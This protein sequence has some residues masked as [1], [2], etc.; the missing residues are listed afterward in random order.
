MKLKSIYESIIAEGMQADPRG[1]LT[2]Q[3]KLKDADAKFKSL[4]KEKREYFDRES[5]INPYDDTRIL[6]G[7]PDAEIKTAI[8]GIDIDTS[9]LLL[10]DRLNAKK[11]GKIDLAVSHHPQGAAYAHFYKVMDMQADIFHNIGVPINICEQL[12][13][14]RKKEVSR[15]IHAANHYRSSDAARLLNIPFICCHT[16]AD[17]HAASFLQKSMDK[18][19]PKRLKDIMDILEN[20]EEY[21]IDR[22]QHNGPCILFGKPEN[23]AGKIFIDMTGGTEGPKEIIDNLLHAGVGTIIGMHLSE[24]HYKKLQGKNINVI[25]AGHISSDNLGMN[26]LF[27]KIEKKGRLKILCCSGFRRIKRA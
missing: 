19:E 5:L 13:E 17:N 14:E 6:N 10:I 18:K 24:E 9:E 11:T 1:K 22:Q 12:V 3:D 2:A 4:P 25:I 23:R 21:K 15:R 7:D 20:I 16:P 26:L 27:D 8:V